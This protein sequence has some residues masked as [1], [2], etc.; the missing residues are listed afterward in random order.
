MAYAKKHNK[1]C[2]NY[3]ECP[4]KGVKRKM[5]A[6]G[7][8][9]NC[10]KH[11]ARLAGHLVAGTRMRQPSTPE[12]RREQNFASH[13]LRT[14]GIDVAEWNRIL[15]RQGGGCA[16][17]SCDRLPNRTDH[18][19]STGA[20]RGILCHKHNIVLHHDV[21]ATDLRFL[22]D[23]MNGPAGVGSVGRALPLGERP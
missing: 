10:Y 3:S 6:H 8:C 22:A 4:S 12:R 20:V 17:P 5:Y 11:A 7:L 14:Y 9:L 16:V 15:E 2:T 1:I 21:T 19:H 13:I 23:Y 18:D